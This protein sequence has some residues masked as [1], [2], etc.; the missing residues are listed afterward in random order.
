MS[1]AA[2]S[3]SA[4]Y[5]RHRYPDGHL[6]WFVT[7]YGLSKAILSD[8]RFSG[9]PL[10]SPTD[11]GGFQ[12]AMSGPESAGDLARIDPPQ[13]TRVRRA[14]TSF[15][16]VKRVGER[17]AKIE[18]VVDL[19][20]DA[21]EAH[22]PP[23]DFVAMFSTPV[24]GM[25]IC[26]TL[27]VPREDQVRF[28][29][30]TE[31]LV[32]GT[33]TTRAEKKAAIDG[34]YAYIR[35]VIADKRTHPSDDL[36]SE[37]INGGDLN[38]DELTGTM[39]FLFA[40]GHGTVI[41]NLG[42][43]ALFLLSDRD[44]WEAARADLSSIDRTVE[45]LLRL[46][47]PV[48][49]MTRTATADVELADGAVIREGEAVTV[50]GISPSGDPDRIGDPHHFDPSRAPS[51]HL[52]FGWGRHMCLGQHLAR[53]ELQVA[54]EG[55]LRRFPNLHLAVPVEQVPLRPMEV[56]GPIEIPGRDP[57][58]VVERLPVAW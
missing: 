31:I 11:D 23:A 48:V 53:L 57:L 14:Q 13:H 16:T 45:E 27:G 25:V 43:S 8:A 12:E 50:Y 6:G 32:A 28:V 24:A 37:L 56:L 35:E 42:L 9:R 4:A 18:E 20:L 36:L 19:C 29:Q 46:L 2:T 26:D 44:R 3:P 30:P 10:R 52:A 33:Q 58:Y 38:D 7:D 22:G 51:D 54:L 40:A 15:F 5:F 34:M 21:M 17:R 39:L 41:E 1:A 47:S 49:T 55:L